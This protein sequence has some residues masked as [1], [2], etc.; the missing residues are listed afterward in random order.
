MCKKCSG[1]GRQYEEVITGAWM[2]IPCSCERKPFDYA[3]FI[4]RLEKRR[5]NKR[6]NGSC[7]N[8][9][10]LPAVEA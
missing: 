3:G 5:G 10:V 1:L 7:S 9:T 6:E 2:V 4:E 8:G